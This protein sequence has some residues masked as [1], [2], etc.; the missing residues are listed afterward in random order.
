MFL[1]VCV[2]FGMQSILHMRVIW[3]AIIELEVELALHGRDPT[4]PGDQCE[5]GM[6]AWIYSPY[7]ALLA[8]D[9]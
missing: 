5:Q 4:L 6:L 7:H 1:C 8:Y 2:R 9:R 3:N